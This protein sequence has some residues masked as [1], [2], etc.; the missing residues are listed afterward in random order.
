[1]ERKDKDMV[2]DIRDEMIKAWNSVG[3]TCT[4]DINVHCE[5]G[6]S[7]D[8]C[9]HQPKDDDKINGLKEP[10]KIEWQK[11][12]DDGIYPKCPSCGEMPY[13]YERCVFCGQKFIQDDPKLQEYAEEPPQETIQCMICGGT[14]VGKRAKSNGHF[15]GQCDKCGAIVME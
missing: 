9:E 14:V 7:C 3:H 10:V 2:D 6:N 4:W 15:H 5:N 12:Y 13:S 8:E 11:S 1:M